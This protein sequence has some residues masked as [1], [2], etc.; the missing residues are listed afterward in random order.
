MDL[1]VGTLPIWPLARLNTNSSPS[2]DIYLLGSTLHQYWPE[3]PDTM[4]KMY[5]NMALAEQS[6]P[7][8]YLLLQYLGSWPTVH[9]I[10]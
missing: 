3:N 7:Y 2:C 10:N 8:D 5:E 1:V 6:E 9:A 4:A